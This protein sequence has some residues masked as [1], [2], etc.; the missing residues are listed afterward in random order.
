MKTGVPQGSVLSPLL[1]AI[2]LHDLPHTPGTVE[3]VMA[4]DITFH[5][6]ADSIE[7]AEETLQQAVHKFT[8]WTDQWGLEIN[9]AK[10]RLMC[11]TRK[12]IGKIPSV[13]VKNKAVQFVT[14][15]CFLGVI[16]DG[17]R[18]T[19][20][21]HIDHLKTTC[22]SRLNIMKRVASKTWGM[23]SKNLLILYKSFIRS[24]LEYASTVYSSAP[25]SQLSKLDVIQSTAL[26]IATGAFKSS[27]TTSLHIETNI[28]PLRYLREIRNVTWFSKLKRNSI[29]NPLFQLISTDI[30]KIHKFNWTSNRQLPASVRACY[31]LSSLNQQWGSFTPLPMYPLTPPW[32]QWEDILN[33][34]FPIDTRNTSP[35]VIQ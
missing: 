13:N 20:K 12:R 8:N 34:N 9:P 21:H 25:T 24:K 14:K 6:T 29:D 10:S 19:W 33:C 15:H 31:S 35:T 28:L 27:P 22:M 32:F 23:D 30:N 26:R 17:P 1:F 2:L 18:L 5:V 4:D 16:L 3:L 11:F 7:Q